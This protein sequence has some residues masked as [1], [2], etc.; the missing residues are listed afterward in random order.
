MGCENVILVLLKH[1]QNEICSPTDGAQTQVGFVAERRRARNAT[2]A[3]LWIKC[4]QC[5]NNLN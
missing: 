5:G 1:E 4:L 2:L 3:N